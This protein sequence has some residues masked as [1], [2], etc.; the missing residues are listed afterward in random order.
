[1]RTVSLTG[2]VVTLEPTLQQFVPRTQEA[3]RVIEAFRGLRSAPHDVAEGPKG[4][5][6]VQG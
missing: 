6:N 3:Q 5:G 4:Q 1:M 2:R